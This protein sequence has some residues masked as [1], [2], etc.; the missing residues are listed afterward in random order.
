MFHKGHGLFCTLAHGFKTNL[1][2]LVAIITNIFNS[3]IIWFVLNIHDLA[4]V[5]TRYKEI[6]R[7]DGR[8]QVIKSS[9]ALYNDCKH[10]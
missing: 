10:V 8:K 2:Y 6:C 1:S 7:E 9:R 3:T 5:S 4:N